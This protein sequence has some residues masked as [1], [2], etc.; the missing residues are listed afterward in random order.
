MFITVY[1]FFTSQSRR[2][3]SSRHHAEAAASVLKEAVDSLTE[4][5]EKA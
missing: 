4:A 5:Q 3:V 1:T 2:V